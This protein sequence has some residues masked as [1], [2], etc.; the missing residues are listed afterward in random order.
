MP[1]QQSI[2]C[3]HLGGA[4]AA[5]FCF[6]LPMMMMNACRD[7]CVGRRGSWALGVSPELSLASSYAVW[8]H[9]AR[10][11]ICQ[12]QI[13]RPKDL[14]AADT[15]QIACYLRLANRLFPTLALATRSRKTARAHGHPRPATPPGPPGAVSVRDA[16][17]D[18]PHCMRRI[19]YTGLL[20]YWPKTHASLLLKDVPTE[21]L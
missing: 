15:S 1:A 7:E 17:R 6:F 12:I 4:A 8:H 10:I 20:R 9:G 2:A 16:C 3:D 14:L 13:V 19:L 21:T 5:V 18:A 11:A